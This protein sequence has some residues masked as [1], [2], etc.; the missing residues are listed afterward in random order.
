MN[1]SSMEIRDDKSVAANRV[2]RRAKTKSQEWP[3][4]PR[5]KQESRYGKEDRERGG[6]DCSRS[7]S[8][9]AAK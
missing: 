2:A 9:A 1:T 8:E 3:E 4:W 6:T 5:P 7:P